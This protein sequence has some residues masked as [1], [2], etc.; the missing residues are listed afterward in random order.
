MKEFVQESLRSGQ[1]GEDGAAGSLLRYL[2]KVVIGTHPN[3]A[4]LVARVTVAVVMFPHGAR[5]V[6][7]AGSVAEGFPEP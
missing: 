5:K 1:I 7:R 6:F 3:T 4:A 2:V